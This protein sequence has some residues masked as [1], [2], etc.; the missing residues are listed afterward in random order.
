[1]KFSKN[2]YL[3]LGVLFTIDFITSLFDKSMQHELFLWEVNIWF[4]RIYRFAIAFLFVTLYFN[5]KKEDSKI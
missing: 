3:V 1:M 4:Y 2:G 5:Q